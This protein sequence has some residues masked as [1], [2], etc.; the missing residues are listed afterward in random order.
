MGT[1]LMGLR[2][3]RRLG[4]LEAA[5]RN[6]VTN[7]QAARARSACPARE[8]MPIVAVKGAMSETIQC[9]DCGYQNPAGSPSCERCH[10]P[11]IEDAVPGSVPLPP[12]AQPAA[13]APGRRR[14]N[15][16]VRET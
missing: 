8:R 14:G 15:A 6:E 3:A 16:R 7:V 2:E 11:L 9:P 13:G 12:S 10:F 1:N 4:L 5:A